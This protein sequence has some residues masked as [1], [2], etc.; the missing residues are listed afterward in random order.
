M[1]KPE[2]I[3]KAQ[4]ALKLHNEKKTNSEIALLVSKKFGKCSPA[5][6]IEYLTRNSHKLDCP[7]CHGHGISKQRDTGTLKAIC[8]K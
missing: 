2:T 3:A 1:S 5:L 8:D 6:V 7:T 4:M